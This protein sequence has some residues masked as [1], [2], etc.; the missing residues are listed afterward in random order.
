MASSLK[1][2]VN[3]IFAT[4]LQFLGND[5]MQ[6]RAGSQYGGIMAVSLDVQLSQLVDMKTP[7][8]VFEEVKNI[9]IHHYPITAFGEVRIAFG[10]FNELFE[11]SYPGY[12][13]C[14]TKF[15]DKIH[16]MDALLAIARL[17]DGY[18]ISART[19]IPVREARLALIATIFH[20]TGY[21]QM[22]SDR[23]GTGAKY[24]LHHVQRSVD[25]VREYFKNKGYPGKDA[26]AAGRIIHCTGLSA[27]IAS[28]G[29]ETSTERMLGHM[30]GTADLMGQMGSRTYL[31][32]LIYLYR[33]FRE[34]H[35][36]GYTSEHM[37][38]EKTLDFYEA[39]EKRLKLILNGVNRYLK[40]HFKKRYG[41]NQ[42]LYREAIE[43]QIC[44]LEEILK[45]K[46]TA[47]SKLLK[48]RV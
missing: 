38:L 48:R 7:A 46:K 13:A 6:F 42:D 40:V 34:G 2:A 18:N 31:E 21:I 26:S 27:D 12:R 5:Q 25:F 9:F 11:G 41:I 28:M 47:Y 8:A 10:D 14:N 29:F 1:N 24:T 36:K 23:K 39:T 19:R 3:L 32:R 20:D 33:E 17:I 16:T 44:Y 37:L 45:N 35:V 43:K 15:H 22:K 30:L 4:V